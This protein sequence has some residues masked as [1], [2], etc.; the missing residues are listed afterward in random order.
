MN[1]VAIVAAILVTIVAVYLIARR[2]GMRRAA[3]SSTV[4]IMALVVFLLLG[5]QQQFDAP[6]RPLLR[7]ASGVMTI[8]ICSI[9]AWRL[10]D[11]IR[12]SDRS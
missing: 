3:S 5:L 9:M 6:I 1:I 12:H 2:E 10:Y 11:F 8:A 4:V 7:V